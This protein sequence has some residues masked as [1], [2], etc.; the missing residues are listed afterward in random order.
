MAAEAKSPGVGSDVD[1]NYS[2][3]DGGGGGGGGFY[4]GPLAAFEA[5]CIQHF[6]DGVGDWAG[7]Q[8]ANQW[9]RHTVDDLQ[10]TLDNARAR[11]RAAA[12]AA[13]LEA[14]AMGTQNPLLAM[15]SQRTEGANANVDGGSGGGD[16]CD[17]G[18]DGGDGGGGGGSAPARRPRM[19]TWDEYKAWLQ[20][21]QRAG[22]AA[23]PAR[24]AGGGLTVDVGAAEAK[25][26]AGSPSPSPTKRGRRGKGNLRVRG[27][28]LLQDGAGSL[29]EQVCTSGGLATP[30]GSRA[31]LDILHEFQQTQDAIGRTLASPEG[32]R[33]VA[34]THT[35]SFRGGYLVSRGA[36]N[37]SLLEQMCNE[38]KLA[39]PKSGG[40]GGGGGGGSPSK[41][42]FFRSPA[43]GGE[44]SPH[45][46]SP[47]AAAPGAAAADAAADASSGLAEWDD[48][49]AG[50]G[51]E[52]KVAATWSVSRDG[53]AG[54]GGGGGGDADDGGPGKK[55]RRSRV[56]RTLQDMQS[57]LVGFRRLSATGAKK[58]AAGD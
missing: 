26:D 37:L 20:E 43:S 13:A 56:R 47:A 18:G 32:K 8:A 55:S 1:S 38:G 31:R 14:E 41:G 4:P 33:A 6:D 53:G 54:G 39:T 50:G 29:L 40:G 16:G 57:F 10:S 45:P 24:R 7:S 17:G 51:D 21:Q 44:A 5:Y 11:D 22:R 27:G 35:R 49:A 19:K 28:Y 58:K 3:D 46:A 52:G 15:R 12:T 2:S 36:G 23:R 48:A 34:L 30:K 42:G 25:F 9:R